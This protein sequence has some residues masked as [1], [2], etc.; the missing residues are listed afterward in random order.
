[1]AKS[2]LDRMLLKRAEAEKKARLERIQAQ[3]EAIYFAGPAHP[4]ARSA[5]ANALG[6]PIRV[7]RTRSVHDNISGPIDAASP[8]YR[9]GVL[10]RIWCRRCDIDRAETLVRGYFSDR[11]EQLR[12][13]YVEMGETCDLAL[14]KWEL[15][16]I[17]GDH[18]IG[19]WDD[20]EAEAHWNNE[21]TNEVR[22]EVAAAR[23][24][25]AAREQQGAAR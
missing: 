2:T 3:Y 8:Y 14:L 7:G 23:A 12:K 21:F 9:Q 13:A 20:V 22:A 19:C 4:V 17:I 15:Q 6:W 16:I 24:R 18:G 5:G 10:F 1:M 11:V 25:R